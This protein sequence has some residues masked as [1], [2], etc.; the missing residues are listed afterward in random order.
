MRPINKETKE[1]SGQFQ[2]RDWAIPPAYRYKGT[3]PV[4]AMPRAA[5]ETRLHKGEMEPMQELR[6]QEPASPRG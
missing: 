6:Q 1:V 2:D 3:L 4:C 5:G